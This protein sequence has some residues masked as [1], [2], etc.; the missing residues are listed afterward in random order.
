MPIKFELE[1]NVVFTTAQRN[2]FLWR[3]AGTHRVE[4]KIGSHGLPRV[5]DASDVTLDLST[6]ELKEIAAVVAK[7]LDGE[8]PGRIAVVTNS[9]FL[10]GLACGYRELTR[11]VNPDFKV[12]NNL[13][14][15]R[16]WILKT[17]GSGNA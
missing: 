10:H 6:V 5:F 12:C 11:A 3:F 4:E 8:A 13:A 2:S 7:A 15:A 14:E 9:A 17:P 16:I 1:Q